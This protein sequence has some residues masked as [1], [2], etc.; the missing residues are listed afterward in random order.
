AA[1]A[2]ASEEAAPAPASEEAAPAPASEEETPAPASEEETPAPT[3][4][5]AAPTPTTETVTVVET[6]SIDVPV[7]WTCDTYNPDLCGE[8]VFTAV[9]PDSID[10]LSADYSLAGTPSV[11]V[12]VKTAGPSP[13]ELVRWVG[14]VKITLN[15]DPGVFP[16]GNLTL[17]AS[18]VENED[19]LTKI[20]ESVEQIR[21]DVHVPVAYTFDI[22]V[23]NESGCELQPNN[24]A[25]NVTLKFTMADAKNANLDAEVYHISGDDNNLSAEAL[26]ADVKGS[27]ITAQTDGFSY[28]VVEFT[29]DDIQYV[30]DGDSKVALSEILSFVGIEENGEITSVETSNENLFKAVFED[31]WYIQAVAP[32]NTAEWMKVTI[33]DI[34]Y[35][36]LVTDAAGLPGARSCTNSYGDVFLGGNYIE[37]GISKHGSFGTSNTYPSGGFHRYTV[38]LQSDEDGWDIGNPPTSGDYFLP[39]NPEERWAI[40]YKI[41]STKYIYEVADR[42]NVCTPFKTEPLVKDCSDIANNLLAAE[43]TAVTKEDVEVY[44]RYSFGVDDKEYATDV[45]IK[46]KGSQT[47]SDVRFIRTFDP[48]QDSEKSSTSYTYNKV[49]C[50]PVLSKASGADNYCMVVAR[51][52]KTLNG[53]FFLAV[54]NRARATSHSGLM[55]PGAFAEAM[56]DSA[57]V[58][59]KTYAE[60]TDIELTKDMISA[61]NINGHIHG[62]NGIAITI[63]E[64]T[65]NAGSDMTLQYYSSLDPNVQQSLNKLKDKLGLHINFE[66]EVITGLDDE[67]TEDVYILVEDEEDDKWLIVKHPDGTYTIYEGDS[68]VASK[69]VTTGKVEDGIAIIEDWYGHDIS[70]T[71]IDKNT[72]EPL[73]EPTNLSIPGRPEPPEDPTAPDVEGEIPI[74]IQESDVETSTDSVTIK[75]CVD[76]QDYIIQDKDGNAIPGVKWTKGDAKGE[77]TFTGLNPGTDY[78]IRTRFS[79]TDTAPGSKP[80]EGVIVR[81]MMMFTGTVA[82]TNYEEAYDSAEHKGSVVC[83]VDG[84]SITYS[85]SLGDSAVFST[86]EPSFEDAGNYT[87]YFKVAKNGY[88]TYYGEVKVTIKQREIKVS[89]IK[90]NGKVYDRTNAS[91]L[92]FSDVVLDGFVTG[93]S[94]NL[95][96]ADSS[97]ADIN[98]GAS[99]KVNI[100]NLVLEGEDLANYVLAS[101]GQ[102]T[103]AYAEIA[104]KVADLTF[105]NLEFVYDGKE[106]NPDFTVSG[107]IDGDTCEATVTDKQIDAGTYEIEATALSNPNYKLPDDHS[108]EFV[109]LPRALTPDNTLLE[110]D[111]DKNIRVTDTGLDVILENDKDYSFTMTEDKKYVYI[112]ITGKNNYKD[113]VD[114]KISIQIPTEGEGN[115]ISFVDVDESVNEKYAP[116]IAPISNEEGMLLIEDESCSMDSE[117]KE[118]IAAG[119]P[120]ISYEANVFITMTE[121]D[122]E[123]VSTDDAETI[124]GSLRKGQKIGAFWDINLYLSYMVK[125]AASEEILDR[126]KDQIKESKIPTKITISVPKKLQPKDD[127][128]IRTYYVARVHNGEYEVLKKSKKTKITFS[129]D[130]FSTYTLLYKDEPNPKPAFIETVSVDSPQTGD[131]NAYWLFVTMIISGLGFA[132]VELKKHKKAKQRK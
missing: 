104:Q 115:I 29:Y 79:A 50:N 85:T 37:V 96:S 8:Y 87:Y 47:L 42:N 99:V 21:E 63:R 31:S 14:S 68:P 2:P 105:E 76:G 74:E 57:A 131:T 77:V 54:D 36:I 64:A 48:D 106:H 25:G 20:D 30:L 119:D 125:D 122:A 9:L 65:L 32:F 40:A 93:D 51:G 81:T 53:F 82:V 120:D 55:M 41:G 16:E 38:G 13:V 10:G 69:E 102:Q 1:P 117:L 98:A 43:F 114:K 71:E 116:K 86:T 12:T 72:K 52:S 121:Q 88:Y 39:G 11:K 132:V 80:S 112:T 94:L 22:K 91:T 34:T 58:T 46:N 100:S 90:A 75:N 59:A 49:I 66:D 70:F 89:G 28:Y 6:K 92:D 108:E 24:E 109:I 124:K 19:T 67:T 84:A 78:L 5:E 44:V 113:S 111:K 118:K 95:K 107:I 33:G 15:A 97:F 23:L 127:S 45:V 61:G 7:S 3:N 101:S 103:E 60:D 56:W 27:S 128:V 17:V 18:E 26:S 62:D 110:L 126:G 73:S 123:T 129:T 83:S 130:K 4:E 35:E